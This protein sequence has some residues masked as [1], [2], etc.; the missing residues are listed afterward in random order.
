MRRIVGAAVAALLL[1]L[2]TA[3]AAPA[4]PVTSETWAICY[5]MKAYLFGGYASGIY[6]RTVNEVHW[7]NRHQVVCFYDVPGSSGDWILLYD[8]GNG[9]YAWIH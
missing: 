7:W 6:T 3:K 4:H 5:W 1:T 2:G 8:R 9:S